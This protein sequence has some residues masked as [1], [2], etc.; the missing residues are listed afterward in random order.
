[1]EELLS[2]EEGWVA[3]NC[4]DYWLFYLFEGEKVGY[5]GVPLVKL[6]MDITVDY[7]SMRSVQ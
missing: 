5:M 1:M 2:S 6:G 3:F 4:L 7:N